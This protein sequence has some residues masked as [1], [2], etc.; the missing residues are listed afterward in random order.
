MTRLVL[1]GLQV[2]ELYL[3]YFLF[4]SDNPLNFC[5]VS[6]ITLIIAELSRAL[7]LFPITVISSLGWTARST[8]YPL[9]FR[10]PQFETSSL[11]HVVW[12]VNLTSVLHLLQTNTRYAKSWRELKFLL[13]FDFRTPAVYPQ[14]HSQRDLGKRYFELCYSSIS[15]LWMFLVLLYIK[16]QLLPLTPIPCQVYFPETIKG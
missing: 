15:C 1:L 5:Y 9:E 7:V 14:S 4:F 8:L 3:Y 16:S 10:S 6:I 2:P 11:S 12:A 13:C